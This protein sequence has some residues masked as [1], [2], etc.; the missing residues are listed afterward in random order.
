MDKFIEE[1]NHIL[2]TPSKISTLRSHNK[3][4]SVAKELSDTLSVYGIGPSRVV[5][6]LSES[7]YEGVTP[8]QIKGHRRRNRQSNIGNE[9]MSVIRYFH[10]KNATDP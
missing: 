2:T 10:S 5:Q 9:C 1:H 6:V 4:S 8:Q 7:S 3:L